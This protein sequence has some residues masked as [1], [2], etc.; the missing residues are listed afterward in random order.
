MIHL[1]EPSEHSSIRVIQ[2]RRKGLEYVFH[3][4]GLVGVETLELL[5]LAVRP[6]KPIRNVKISIIAKVGIE[7]A[8]SLH[9]I[10]LRCNSAFNQGANL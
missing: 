2:G 7:W 3:V 5:Q 4:L 6:S 8:L 9:A 10:R 1:L